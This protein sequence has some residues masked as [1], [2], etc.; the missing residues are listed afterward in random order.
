MADRIKIA[1]D[2]D[3][4]KS[5]SMIVKP[6]YLSM[7]SSIYF[8]VSIRKEEDSIAELEKLPFDPKLK[9][10]QSYVFTDPR[11]IWAHIY[12]RVKTTT[13][14]KNIDMRLTQLGFEDYTIRV[15]L[16]KVKK[17]QLMQALVGGFYFGKYPFPLRPYF[18]E[19]RKN[20]REFLELRDQPYE[21]VRQPKFVKSI[22][23]TMSRKS[24]GSGED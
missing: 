21:E 8:F 3:V 24:R 12:M 13:S 14:A 5:V 11:E 18:R 2:K 15:R 17:E 1:S 4:L 20:E 6:D 9:I 10:V 19:I 7:H 23:E 22:R 16:T